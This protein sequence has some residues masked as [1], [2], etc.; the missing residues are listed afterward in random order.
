MPG[1]K[2]EKGALMRQLLK[3]V[4]QTKEA[5]RGMFVATPHP[6][7]TEF[8]G[9]FGLDFLCIDAEHSAIGIE[10]IQVMIQGAHAKE[11]NCIVR[12]PALIYEW[13]SRVLDAGA[14]GLL[15]PQIR[16][17]EEVE[18]VQQYA[19]YPPKGRRGCGP[20]RLWDYGASIGRIAELEDPDQYTNLIFQ[21][22][23]K[24]AVRNLDEI[25]EVSKADMYF[26]GPGDLSLDLGVF[27]QMHD[28]LL[29]GSMDRIKEKVHAAGRRIGVFANDKAAAAAFFADGYDMCLINSELGLLTG[30][31]GDL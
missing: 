2:R 3:Q 27:G 21:I 25:L 7:M 26:I 5:V 19:L 23:T 31:L 4:I 28:P 12:I 8:L 22:E 6:V 1:S 18:T 24:E 29:T 15:I 13:V 17:A 30:I 9:G 16:T 10:T 20:S 14:D 11:Q